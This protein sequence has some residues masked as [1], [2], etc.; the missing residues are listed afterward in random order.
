MR[1]AIAAPNGGDAAGSGGIDQR[2][3]GDNNLQ[4]IIMMPYSMVARFLLREVMMSA[5]F[6]PT[7]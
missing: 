2:P 6:Q 3:D 4:R 5:T 1:I 7:H